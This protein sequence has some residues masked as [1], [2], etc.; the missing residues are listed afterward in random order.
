M[1]LLSVFIQHWK[2]YQCENNTKRQQWDKTIY[3]HDFTYFFFFQFFFITNLCN[4]VRAFVVVYTSLFNALMRSQWISRYLF[5]FV[6]TQWWF[7]RVRFF[8]LKKLENQI[9]FF[10]SVFFQTSV[11]TKLKF[12]NVIFYAIVL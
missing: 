8:F 2:L 5:R 9:I 1:S 6:V 11:F 4:H 12:Y 10:N 7:I 3:K